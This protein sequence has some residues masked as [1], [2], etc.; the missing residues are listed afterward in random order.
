[1]VLKV[2]GGGGGGAGIGNAPKLAVTAISQC[3]IC[4]ITSWN[5]W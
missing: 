2:A 1:M 4:D 3:A 5:F